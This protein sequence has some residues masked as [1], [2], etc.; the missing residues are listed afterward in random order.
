[1]RVAVVGVGGTGSAA[2]RFLAQAGHEAVGFEQFRAGHDRGSSHGESRIIRYTYPDLLYTQM[3]ADAYPLWGEL[4]EAAG[5]ELFVRCGGLMF[6]PEGHPRLGATETVLAACRL[7]FERL[8]P[9]RVSERFPAVRLEP[10]E[11]AIFQRETGFLR[12]SR[13]VL[14]NVR[15]ALEQGATLREETPVLGITSRKDEVLVETAAGTEAFDRLILTA[16]PWMGRLASSLSLPLCVTRQQVV[17]LHIARRPETFAPGIFPV[18]IDAGV[19]YYG[20]PSDGVISG[21]KLAAHQPGIEVDPD[22]V[23][24]AVDETYIREAVRLATR[25]FPDLA[26]AITAANTCLYTSTPD[27]HFILDR[28]HGLPNVWLASGC[29][30]HGFKFT[31]LLGKIAADLATGGAYGRDLSRFSATRFQHAR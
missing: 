8:T 5:E 18:W 22:Q 13:C 4:E 17:Y 10:G 19:R 24:R 23:N 28:L 16:G 2:L 11:T 15:L 25:R 7:P 9:E 6:G 3:M 21:V 27:E 30:G 29:S 1:M 20:F 31:V 26:P 14:A 12:A